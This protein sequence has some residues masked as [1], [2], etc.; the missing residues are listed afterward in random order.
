M[1]DVTRKITYKNI[2]HWHKDVFRDSQD[3]PVVYVGNK[4][5][6]KALGEKGEGIKNSKEFGEDAKEIIC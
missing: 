2:L 6:V 1:F 4:V 3:V 5:D